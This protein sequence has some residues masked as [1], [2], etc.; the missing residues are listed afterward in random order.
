MG[1]TSL[2][3]EMPMEDPIFRRT[4]EGVHGKLEEPPVMT[5]CS[6]RKAAVSQG[7]HEL[8]MESGIKLLV[9]WP[10]AFL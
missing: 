5:H 10:W 2:W 8:I 7:S 6:Q 4:L 9:P 1:H 3:Q